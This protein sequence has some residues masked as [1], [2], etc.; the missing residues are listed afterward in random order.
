MIKSGAVAPRSTAPFLF[1]AKAALK[2]L[3]KKE[4]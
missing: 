2:V 4:S 3:S 1:G